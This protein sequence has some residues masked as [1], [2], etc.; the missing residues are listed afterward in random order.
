VNITSREQI[1][2]TGLQPII[3]EL[4][5]RKYSRLPEHIRTDF[6]RVIATSCATCLKNCPY[7]VGGGSREQLWQDATGVYPGQLITKDNI[8]SQIAKP[9]QQLQNDCISGKNISCHKSLTRR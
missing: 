1:I 7:S 8:F 2:A 3:A 5:K 4:G 9:I 6:C